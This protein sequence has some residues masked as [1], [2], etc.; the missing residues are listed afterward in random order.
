[1]NG[2]DEFC[3]VPAA[4]LTLDQ[5]MARCNS[6]GLAWEL[7][8]AKIG[9]IIV[10]AVLIG[11]L[12]LIRR[13]KKSEDASVVVG[14]TF[15]GLLYGALS[16]W[17]GSS[18]GVVLALL[19]PPA[20]MGVMLLVFGVLALLIM[21]A[22]LIKG[23]AGLMKV[24]GTICLLALATGLVV[25]SSFAFQVP[26][27]GRAGAAYE[28]YLWAIAITF[29]STGFVGAL[30]VSLFRGYHFAA[31]WFL[32]PLNA[33]WGLLGNLLGLMNH[34]ASMLFFADYG[35]VQETRRFYV[36]Y[37]AGYHLKAGYDFTEGDAMSATNVVK[38]EAVHVLQHFIFGPIYPL[39]HAAW[40]ALMFVP[41]IFAGWL[42]RTVGA[43]I[44]DFTYYNNPWEVIAYAFG[45]TRNDGSKDL[46][47]RDI[48][49]WI[50]AVVWILGA[51][52]AA[53]AFFAARS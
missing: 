16:V 28:T 15:E 3:K 47:F 32:V 14:N 31:G 18:A 10:G 13:I 17:A 40:I 5:I 48:A 39:S 6:Y 12:V 11:L 35:K 19:L 46:I 7:T 25:A 26:T 24:A 30:I 27:S 41:G 52:A 23:T 21:I 33:S 22:A 8:G 53:I 20:I 44:T 37:D 50:I 38:H 36:R 4:R 42:K 29:A 49:A 9:L 45:G 34:F 2:L 1:M 43:G 51:T